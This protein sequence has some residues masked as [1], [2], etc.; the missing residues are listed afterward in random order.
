M[1][2]SVSFI[3]KIEN[4]EILSFN[5]TQLKYKLQGDTFFHF[6]KQD[7]IILTPNDYYFWLTILDNNGKESICNRQGY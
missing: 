1:T 5:K 6:E 2:K 7:N 4:F 3:E